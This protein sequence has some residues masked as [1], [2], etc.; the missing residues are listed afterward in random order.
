MIFSLS[1]C[2]RYTEMTL[3]SFVYVWMARCSVGGKIALQLWRDLVGNV[4][5][6]VPA[7]SLITQYVHT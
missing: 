5:P 1:F 2:F 7:V 4:A 3:A 6:T